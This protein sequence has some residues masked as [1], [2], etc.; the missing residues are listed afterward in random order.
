MEE[1][2][3]DICGKSYPEDSGRVIDNQRLCLDCVSEHTY[4]CKGM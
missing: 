1:L 4:E 3:C 2:I